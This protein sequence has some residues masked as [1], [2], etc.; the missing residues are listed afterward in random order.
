MAEANRVFISFAIEDAKLR[1]FLVGQAKNKKSPFSFVDM[2]VNEPWDSAWKTNCRTKIKSCDG[3]II[4]VTKNTK[5]AH[6]QLWEINCA[7]EEGIPCLGIWG[8]ADDKPAILPEQ[9]DGVRIV[10]WTWDNFKN[11]LDSL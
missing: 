4:I 9:L 11:W 2:S 1:D 6:G 8:Y 10:N 5:N 7:K 3:V